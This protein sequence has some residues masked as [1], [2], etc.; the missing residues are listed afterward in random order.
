MFG[1]RRPWFA[2]R[3]ACLG[4]LWAAQAASAAPAQTAQLIHVGP[5]RAVKTLAEASR[6]AT[7]GATVLVDSGTY[8]GDTATWNQ[9]RLTLR[10]VGG[11]A[12]LAANGAA[13]EQKGIWVTRGTHMTV[14]G[15]DFEG[16]VVPDR[17]GAGIRLER[18]SLRVLD[19]TFMHNEMGILTNNDPDTE[20]EVVNS[21]FAH[22]QRPD[23]H[24]HNLYAGT[25]RR[26][27]V[28]GSYFHH[29]RSGHLLKSRAAFN[30]ITYN[31]F[32]DESDG[33]ASY[34]LEFPNGGV[35]W[36]VGNIIQQGPHTENQH[37]VSFGAEGYRWPSNELYLAHNTLIDDRA[38]PGVFVRARSGATAVRVINNLLLG[39]AQWDLPRGAELRNN[40]SV[41]PDELD[42]AHRLKRGS[43]AWGKAVDPGAA[44]GVALAPSREYRHPRRSVALDGPA[45]QPGAVQTA[46]APAR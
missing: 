5:Q 24:N 22:N 23:G 38:R 41:K 3:V 10:A 33:R 40:F 32:T 42:A 36:V 29:G 44:H 13:A 37:L 1:E 20:L 25:I 2:A 35:A 18:G 27:T 14:E 26:L 21:E 8:A 46:A 7:D 45:L 19:C 6:L 17:N 31:R 4:I 16:A 12:R 34:E 15:F 28:T 9:H 43:Q 30:H 39:T 11:R